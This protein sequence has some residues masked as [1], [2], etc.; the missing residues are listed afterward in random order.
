[1]ISLTLLQR[2]RT[3]GSNMFFGPVITLSVIGLTGEFL[4]AISPKFGVMVAE[5]ADL[6]AKLR[7]CHS[8]IVTNSEEIAFYGGGK[9]EKKVLEEAFTKEIRQS[10]R[11]YLS[12]LW[13][14]FFE[15]YLMKYV[16]AGAGMV[17]T[18]IPIL[19]GW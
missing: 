13:Y 6:K 16:W 8:R 18:A 10:K 1:M 4:K 19:T 12:R 14:V 11:L 15:Q 17:V 9:V 3:I 5:E 7:H 2:A